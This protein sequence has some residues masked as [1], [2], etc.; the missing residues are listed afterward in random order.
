MPAY[1]MEQDV[2]DFDRQ[3]QVRS[4][5]FVVANPHLAVELVDLSRGQ[6]NS[7]HFI[8]EADSH[9]EVFEHRNRRS[10]LNGPTL[11]FPS[12][13]SSLLATLNF[14]RY[15]TSLMPFT[16]HQINVPAS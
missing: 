11:G 8:M 5:L 16:L 6:L 13:P 4:T 9:L 15:L 10:T 12:I 2:K 14:L 1:F 3:M 7:F